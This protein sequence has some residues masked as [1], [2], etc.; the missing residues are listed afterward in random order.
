[1]GGGFSLKNLPWEGYGYFLEQHN[2]KIFD[3]FLVFK[4]SQ[5][6]GTV[7]KPDDSA[8][9]QDKYSIEKENGISFLQGR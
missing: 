5:S 2:S 4:R 6:M 8:T 1:M 9:Q 7:I 3:M